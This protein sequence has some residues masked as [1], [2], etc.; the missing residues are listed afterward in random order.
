[1]IYGGISHCTEFVQLLDAQ[2]QYS[3][4]ICSCSCRWLPEDYAQMHDST[5]PRFGSFLSNITT[6]DAQG[7]GL[8]EAEA[9][10]ID[11]QQRLLLEA[12]YEAQLSAASPKAPL[13]SAFGVYVGISA[14]DY[15]KL[16]TRLQLPTTAYSATGNLSLS[17]AAGR[18]SYT[19]GLAGPALAVDTACSS[20]LVAT[21]A[22]VAG[23]GLGHC[24]GAAAG[25]VNLV[26]IPDTPALFQ[27]AGKDCATF[28]LELVKLCFGLCNMCSH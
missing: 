3:M 7:F 23:L 24:L 8:S 21:Q 10:L 22:A 4:L 6:F 18:L 15:N 11:P 14:V 19:F 25:G 16:C 13:P 27:K 28:T 2:N 12:F 26:L 1:M 20:G 9:L 5:P 17:V